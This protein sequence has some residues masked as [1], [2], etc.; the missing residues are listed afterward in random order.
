MCRLLIYKGADIEMSTL[1]VRPKHSLIYQSYHSDER[2]RAVNGD[3]FG[4]GWYTD[5]DPC[6]I[7]LFKS[8]T[9]AWSNNNLVN[10]SESISSHCFFAHV[11]DAAF[12]APVSEDNCHPFRYQN[13]LFMHNGHVP[14]FNMIKRKIQNSLSNEAFDIIKGNTDSEHLFALI[15]DCLRSKKD[16]SLLSMADSIMKAIHKVE[17]LME[18]AGINESAAFNV[19]LTNGNEVIALRYSSLSEGHQET[20]YYTHPKKFY[21]D[22]GGEVELREGDTSTSV[23][24]ASEPLSRDLGNWTLLPENHMFLLDKN[25]KIECKLIK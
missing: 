23:V 18:E 10:I 6:R 7:G 9:P 24:L 21:C 22:E 4:L 19:S 8:T 14:K 12:Y 13:Y 2:A 11:R 3:G 25:N 5:G 16:Q 15:I 17:S 20:L 1:I